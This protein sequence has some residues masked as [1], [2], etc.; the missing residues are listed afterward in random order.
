M[1]AKLKSED[2][3]MKVLAVIPARA[4]SKGVP[5]KNIKSLGK[6]PLIGYTVRAALA[7]KWIDTVIVSTDCNKIADIARKEGARVPFLRPSE[8]A[9]D[10]ALTAPVVIHALKTT[11]ELDETTYDAVLLLQPTCPF[12]TAEE[13]D[14]A[15][16]L[17]K[18]GDCTSVVSVKSVDGNHPFRMK[19]IENGYLSNFIDQGFEDMRPRQELPEVFIRDGSI[20]A[21]LSC[22]LLANGEMVTKE[23][24]PIISTSKRNIN[25]DTIHDFYLAERLLD[26]E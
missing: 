18:N 25:I 26:E 1:Q 7:S 4:G 15:V 12:R 2:K 9:T 11:Q 6:T 3:F 22:E 19:R 24:K 23:C 17:L 5:G 20:Y 8:L 21:I 10:N 13:I 16:E 14:L